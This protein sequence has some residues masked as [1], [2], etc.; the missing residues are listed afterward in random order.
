MSHAIRF[1]G[2][3]EDVSVTTLGTASLAGL[4]AVLTDL[5]GEQSYIP[6]MRVLL[7][8]SLLD[9]RG[10][11]PEDL[12]RRIHLGLKDAD[13]IGPSR[14]AVVSGDAR[15]ARAHV[16]R[17]DEPI[18]RAFASAEEARAWLAEGTAAGAS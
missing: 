2:Q 8:H 11:Q 6:G 9:W 15:M 1:G 18:W 16:L 7:D 14:I 10:L 12:L 4:D 3:P 5:L 17:G 13:L